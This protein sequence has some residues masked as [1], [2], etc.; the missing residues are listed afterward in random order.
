MPNPV[1]KP[2][3]NRFRLPPASSTRPRTMAAISTAIGSAEYQNVCDM[4]LPLKPENTLTDWPPGPVFSHGTAQPR[5]TK[6]APASP[7]IPASLADGGTALAGLGGG[8]GQGAGPGGTGTGC[9]AGPGGGQAGAPP[10][11]LGEAHGD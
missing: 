6:S 1:S 10:G 3:T 2:G 11:P 4:G 5:S 9:P 8:T 7:R